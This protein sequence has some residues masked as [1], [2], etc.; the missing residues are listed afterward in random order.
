MTN[1]TLPLIL[2][3][4]ALLGCRPEEQLARLERRYQPDTEYTVQVQMTSRRSLFRT[5]PGEE[6]V[7]AMD[8]IFQEVQTTQRLR[9]G[10]VVEGLCRLEM[11][12]LDYRL[13]EPGLKLLMDLQGCVGQADYDT[14]ANSLRWRGLADTTWQGGRAQ[15]DSGWRVEVLGRED[16]ALYLASSVELL[17]AS[18][19]DSTRELLP[20][21]GY[22][23][24][25]RQETT[26]GGYQVAWVEKRRV[27]LKSLEKG[28][29]T[30][31]VV[32]ELIPEALPDGPTVQLEGRGGGRLEF[33]LARRCTVAN[34]LHSEMSI[35]I[36]DGSVI[37]Q[38]RSET[39]LDIR[40]TIRPLPAAGKE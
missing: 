16:A 39:G 25:Q 6:P 37:W 3:G 8:E 34:N 21:Q 31:D 22:L 33:D 13:K 26:I 10:P 12:M 35:E 18:L 5:L 29:A 30:L 20:G 32:V 38:A 40:T 27:T 17:A 28:I 15:A 14:S 9:V 2:L 7:P 36:N 23:E 24:N 11:E 1:K 4:L 19:A